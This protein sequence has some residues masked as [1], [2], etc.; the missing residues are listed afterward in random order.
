MDSSSGGGGSGSG[1]GGFRHTLPNIRT[2]AQADHGWC[3]L[4]C[5]VCARLSLYPQLLGADTKKLQES[6]AKGIFWPGNLSRPVES[7]IEYVRWS[8][9]LDRRLLP[10]LRKYS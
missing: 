7:P 5:A 3:L 10:H 2:V 9:Y 6:M 8:S 4:A 1:S